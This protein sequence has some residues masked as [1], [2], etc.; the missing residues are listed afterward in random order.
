MVTPKTTPQRNKHRKT[1]SDPRYGYGPSDDDSTCMDS[2]TFSELMPGRRQPGQNDSFSSSLASRR[3]KGPPAPIQTGSGRRYPD[4][5]H[6]VELE[7]VSDPISPL[8]QGRFENSQC[9]DED[10]A[11]MYSQDIRYSGHPESLEVREHHHTRSKSSVNH[12]ITNARAWAQ[13]GSPFTERVPPPHPENL[14]NRPRRSKSNAEGLRQAHFADRHTPTM[15]QQLAVPPKDTELF[16]PLQFYFRG[17]DF[18]TVKKGEKTM[19]GDN[20]WLE[21]TEKLQETTKKT[22]HK[23]TGILDS[24]KKI[25]KDMV[26]AM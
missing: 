25:A 7:P 10:S 11:S 23:K 9:M 26:R 21:R 3:Q 17:Q 8:S 12:A 16:S 14:V 2:P 5:P 18:P 4:M 20:G 1:Q 6:R 15:P 13:L 22:P 24:I 19:I